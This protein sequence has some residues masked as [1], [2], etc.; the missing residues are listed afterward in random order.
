MSSRFRAVHSG[1]DLDDRLFGRT[2]YHF[3]RAQSRSSLALAGVHFLAYP[4]L[5]PWAIFFRPYGP[6]LVGTTTISV[7]SY[8]IGVSA[9]I[10]TLGKTGPSTSLGAG[11]GWGTLRSFAGHKK[12]PRLRARPNSRSLDS[13][14][15][16]KTRLAHRSG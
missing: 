13:R 15:A 9:K 7:F 3:A 2:P 10:P 1:L 4:G 5:P 6:Q 12:A 14:S 11:S 16:P 8:V